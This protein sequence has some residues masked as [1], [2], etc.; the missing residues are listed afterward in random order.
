MAHEI[1]PGAG[2]RLDQAYDDIEGP[3]IRPQI[4]SALVSFVI[5]C[6]ICLFPV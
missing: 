2:E 5:E 6:V 3:A 1:E 4:G